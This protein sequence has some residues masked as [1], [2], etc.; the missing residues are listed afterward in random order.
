MR[1]TSM[2]GQEEEAAVYSPANDTAARFVA[3]FGPY[4]FWGA[5]CV[6]ASGIL[7]LG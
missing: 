6:I 4:L 5:L 2:N 7:L 1:E 3:Y